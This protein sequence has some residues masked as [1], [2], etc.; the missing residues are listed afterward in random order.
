MHLRLISA[1][2]ES[3]RRLPPLGVFVVG[4]LVG[5]VIGVIFASLAFSAYLLDFLVMI[6]DSVTAIATVV[7]AAATISLY[8]ATRVLAEST[9][10]LSE[11][12]GRRE[13]RLRLDRLV[14]LSEKLIKIEPADLVGPLRTG[15][16]R[17]DPNAKRE[18]LK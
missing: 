1:L 5:G 18:R 7:L 3:A 9:R 11:I 8:R 17:H 4:M 16:Y 2:R 10:A 15:S 13:R 14:Y 12:E 6:R